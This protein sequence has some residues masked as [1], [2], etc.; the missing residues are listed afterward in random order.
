MA[1]DHNRARLEY[2]DF[3]YR[4]WSRRGIKQT[5]CLSSW[6]LQS[7]EK[8]SFPNNAS[9]IVNNYSNEVLSPGPYLNLPTLQMF[10]FL[11]RENLSHSD[12]G[13]SHETIKK[14][15][16]FFSRRRKNI[17]HSLANR[18]TLTQ[19]QPFSGN[20][21]KENFLPV[22]DASHWNFEKNLTVALDVIKEF[23]NISQGHLVDSVKVSIQQS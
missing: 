23:K 14:P 20:V 12:L 17:V 1:E 6:A 22:R 7:Y 2:R 9:S 13:I 15:K 5:R 16:C 11:A 19:V 18:K 3:V 10:S 21:S 8:L 4:L